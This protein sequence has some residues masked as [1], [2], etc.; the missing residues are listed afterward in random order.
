MNEY[1]GTILEMH[2]IVVVPVTAPNEIES[3]TIDS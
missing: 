3:E 1:F 2:R